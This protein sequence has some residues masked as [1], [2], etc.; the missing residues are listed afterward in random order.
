MLQ[1]LAVDQR[2]TADIFGI[3]VNAFS[4]YQ[5]GRP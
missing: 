1:K 5:S 2:E 4:R 3:G